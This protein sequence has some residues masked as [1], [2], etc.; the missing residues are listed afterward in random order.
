MIPC[1]S[2]EELNNLVEEWKSRGEKVVFTNGVFDILHLG[3][4]TYLQKASELGDKLVVAINDDASVKKL[5]KGAE[6]PINPQ[7]ARTAVICALRCVS[8]TIIFNEDTPLEVIKEILPDVLVKGSDYDP[9]EKDPSRKS[10]IVGS[11]EVAENGGK[12][13]AIDLVQGYSTTGIVNR[14]K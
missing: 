8:A 12:V 11:K 9:D 13:V 5:N 3:H 10:Y 14:M 7:D 6:R 1:Q 4:V 2:I